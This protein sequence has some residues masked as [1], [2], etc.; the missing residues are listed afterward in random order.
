MKVVA[1]DPLRALGV[2]RTGRMRWRRMARPRQA[3]TRSRRHATMRDTA[4][5]SAATSETYVHPPSPGSGVREDKSATGGV[6]GRTLAGQQRERGGADT[7]CHRPPAL[8][9]SQNKL[10]IA[11]KERGAAVVGADGAFLGPIAAEARGDQV[12]ET[13]DLRRADHAMSGASGI[14]GATNAANAA[15]HNYSC[16]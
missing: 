9:T 7:I 15:P 16:N 13:G 8:G 2:G 11:R 12:T 10:R 6:R 5:R 4:P 14:H 3:R 1:W